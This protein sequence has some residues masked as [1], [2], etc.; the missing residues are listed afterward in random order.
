MIPIFL[1]ASLIQ[2]LNMEK[3]KM[4]GLAASKCKSRRKYKQ[5]NSPVKD[6]QLV[7]PAFSVCTDY[8]IIMQISKGETE[9]NYYVSINSSNKFFQY[10]KGKE[11]NGTKRCKVFEASR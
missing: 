3:N 9:T 4:C 8:R 7:S 6:N 5:S 10:F 11:K 2:L 1:R